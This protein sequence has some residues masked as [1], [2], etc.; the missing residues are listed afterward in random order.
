LDNFNRAN[1]A[2]GTNWGGATSGYSIVSNRLDVGGGGAMLWKTASFGANQEAFVT[3]TTV[4]SGGFYQDLLLKSQSATTWESG[5]IDV[6]YDAVGHRVQVWT[7]SNAQG[8]V[9]RGTGIAVTFQNGDQFGVRV[10]ANG[11]VE[12][13]QN[14]L[15]IGS[16]TVSAW[17]YAAN[18]GYIGVLFQDAGTAVLDDFGGGT[19]AP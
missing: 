12:V 9:Q 1:G 10:K 11:T 2:P 13:Y 17:T 7:F 3:L 14:G 19:I 8:W 18:G 5:V 15:L 4:D 16:R 6:S